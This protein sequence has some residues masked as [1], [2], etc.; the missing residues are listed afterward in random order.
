MSSIFALD[1]IFV[2]IEKGIFYMCFPLHTLHQG[3]RPTVISDIEVS[4]FSSCELDA[5]SINVN[6]VL[7]TIVIINQEIIVF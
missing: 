4:Q 7:R 5:Y 3:I 2:R 6:K 1:D